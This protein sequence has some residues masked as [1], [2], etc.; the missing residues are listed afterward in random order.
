MASISHSLYRLTSVLFKVIENAD[1]AFFETRHRPGLQA[2][3][4]QQPGLECR[5]HSK[6]EP[7]SMS[8]TRAAVK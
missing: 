1:F 5:R 2:P 7:G 3:I 8:G 6:L 4:R